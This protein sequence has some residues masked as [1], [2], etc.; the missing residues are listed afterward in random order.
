MR[1]TLGKL[2]V[3]SLLACSQSALAWNPILYEALP[4]NA[5]LIDVGGVELTKD[6]LEREVLIAQKVGDKRIKQTMDANRLR[7]RIVKRFPY[8]AMMLQYTRENDIYVSESTIKS[9]ILELARRQGNP[10]ERFATSFLKS[11]GEG[12]DKVLRDSIRRQYSVE[13]AEQNVRSNVTAVSDADIAKYRADM[14]ARNE[15]MIPLRDKSYQTATNLWL[16]IVAKTNFDAKVQEYVE[17]RDH[18]HGD[19]EW[20]SFT[21]DFF[22]DNPAFQETLRGM[23]VGDITPPINLDNGIMIVKLAGREEGDG[24]RATRY[25]LASLFIAIPY[26]W[27]PQPDDVLRETL[28]KE[29]GDRT[30][31]DLQKSLVEKANITYPSGREWL[32]TRAPLRRKIKK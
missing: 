26:V 9:K 23:A 21:M 6:A 4:H 15:K 29:R 7:Q 22:N 24:T 12:N 27:D 30:W 25:D 18:I 28:W 32:D 1:A 20:G 13:V 31:E 19:P 10:N 17:E 8:E 11:L 16:E 3:M 5:V 2:V 14:L